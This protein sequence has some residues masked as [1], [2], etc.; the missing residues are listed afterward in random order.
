LAAGTTT[1]TERHLKSLPA[2][3]RQ[4]EWSAIG[5]GAPVGRLVCS[6]RIKRQKSNPQEA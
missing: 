2:G 3:K 4:N 5:I 6:I 1:F